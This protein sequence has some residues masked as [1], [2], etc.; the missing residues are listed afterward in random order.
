M[1]C[2]P[3]ITSDFPSMLEQALKCR[4]ALIEKLH[5]E[6]TNAYRLFHGISEGQ[7]GLTIDRYGSLVLVQTFREPLSHDELS[8]VEDSLR[9]K[10]P[11]P[12]AVAYNHRG[13]LPAQSFDEWHRPGP[14]ALAE[15]ECQ[16]FGVRFL[17]RARH[18]GI[19]PWLF[20]DLRAGRRFLRGTVKGL[21]V[22]N[23]FSYTC[24]VGI[25]AAAAGASEVWN[26]DFASSSL[27]IGR[28]NSLLNQIPDDRIRMIDDDCLPVMR[29][30]AGLP[31]GGRRKHGGKF[32]KFEPR[33][34]DLVFLDP[35]AWSKGPF[36]AVDVAGDYP[37]LFKSAVLA[38]RPDGGRVIATNH[39][40]SIG[41]DTWIDVL[42]RCAAKAGRPIRSLE[43][44]LPES[45]FPSFDGRPPLKIVVCE[46]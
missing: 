32:K 31:A 43:P 27:E 40:P 8:G 46:F 3:M 19:D 5:S 44:L 2:V 34:F 16:E 17:I 30:L 26:V 13:K 37:S 45:D 21:S 28:R 1:V 20:L 12:F 14:E 24:S 23:L 15:T 22:L 18:Q 35:P 38:T 25:S 33:Q 10:L 36:G 41:L 39:V 7:P 6:E 29:Q 42:K 9:K 11:Y 4:E